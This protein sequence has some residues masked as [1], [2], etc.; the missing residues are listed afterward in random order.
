[1]EK[2]NTGKVAVILN[3][4]SGPTETSE[5][6]REIRDAF[7]TLDLEPKICL[8]HSGMELDH[9]VRVALEEGYQTI[10]AAGGDG[11]VNATA[12]LLAGTDR[13]LGILP[14]GTWNHFAKDFGIPLTI[15][16]AVRTIAERSYQICRCGHGKRKN[17]Y[18]QQ[19]APSIKFRRANR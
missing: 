14:V 4:T 18:Q 3:V 10:V 7:A 15:P 6:V 1:M 16:E 11:T 17:F 9:R 8:V 19:T 2:T 5:R 13:V 12:S